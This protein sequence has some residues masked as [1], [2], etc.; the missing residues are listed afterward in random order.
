MFIRIASE[1][2]CFRVSEIHLNQIKDG[3]LT[4]LGPEFLR[5]FYSAIS[6]KAVLIVAEENGKI[7]GFVSGCLIL[8][9]F[10][11]FFIKKHIFKLAVILLF[12]LKKARKICETAKYSSSKE[13]SGLPEAELLSIAVLPEFQGKCVSKELLQSFVSELKKREVKAFKVMVGEKLERANRFYIKNGFIFH[14]KGLAHKDSPSNIYV[15]KI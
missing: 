3:F 1:K 7:I 10:Y 11:R 15:F 9:D 4:E 14:S 12:K 5:I 2:D 6:Q 8:K 13:N